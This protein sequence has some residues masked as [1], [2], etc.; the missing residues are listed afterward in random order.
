MVWRCVSYDCKLD[1]K[2]VRCSLTEQR[3][4]QDIIAA[5]VVPQFDYHPLRTML[6]FLDEKAR[7]HQARDVMAY[8][9]D[10]EVETLTSPAGSPD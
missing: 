7:V 5:S 8:L 1:L 4:K 10:E 3:Y 6:I 9:H 2:T